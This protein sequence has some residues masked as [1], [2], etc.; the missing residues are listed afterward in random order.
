M[1]VK[2]IQS[3]K[4]IQRLRRD[5]QVKLFYFSSTAILTAMRKTLQFFASILLGQ[6]PGIIGVSSTISAISGWYSTLNKPFFNPPSWIFGPVWTTLYFLMGISFFLIWTDRSKKKQKA[7]TFFFIQLVLN[8]IWSPVF[9][10]L[11]SPFM[12]LFVIAALWIFIVLTIRQF[13]KISKPAAYLL[14][15]YLF[16]VSFASILN[17][18]IWQLN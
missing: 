2:K 16:W 13:Y 12:A 7:Y 4:P 1:E 15:P 11:E 17:F 10:S 6:L 14:V 8:A 5:R 3:L 9:F 18:S